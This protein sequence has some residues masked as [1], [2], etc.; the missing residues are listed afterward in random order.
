MIRECPERKYR[1]NQP[2]N[3]DNLTTTKE[4][5]REG[6]MKT[7]EM[8]DQGEIDTTLTDVTTIPGE[9]MIAGEVTIAGEMTEEIEEKTGGREV[10][11]MI[12]MIDEEEEVQVQ[13][14]DA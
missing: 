2:E 4:G 6:V 7:E 13:V 3:Q 5:T 10:E 14:N 11:A 8:T 9:M 12:E 1:L